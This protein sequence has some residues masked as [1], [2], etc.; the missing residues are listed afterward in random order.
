[1]TP[2][3]LSGNA[4]VLDVLEPVIPVFLELLWKN[5]ELFGFNC[6]DHFLS[7]ILAVNVPLRSQ[8]WFNDISTPK[9]N[10]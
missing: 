7:D 2:P 3:Y 5:G 8:H 4:P 9:G 10:Y 1:M 6:L